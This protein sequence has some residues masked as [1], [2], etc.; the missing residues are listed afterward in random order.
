MQCYC[1]DTEEHKVQ[2]ILHYMHPSTYL[3]YTTTTTTTTIYTTFRTH[4]KT[5][6][7]ITVMTKPISD[8]E[9]PIILI[10][11][12]AILNATGGS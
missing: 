1:G 7:V 2:V 4:L 6:N 5:N 11:L 3:Y 9:T 10:V 8:S 12:I